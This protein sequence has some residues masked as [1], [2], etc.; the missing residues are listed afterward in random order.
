MK[1]VLSAAQGLLA[2]AGAASRRMMDSGDAEA[3]HDFRVGLR[4]LNT[5]LRAYRRILKGTVSA[6]TRKRLRRVLASTGRARDAQVELVWLKER[7]RGPSA[8]RGAGDLIAEVESRRDEELQEIRRT[9]LRR[10]RRLSGKLV[11][12]LA[13]GRG[14]GKALE[15][16]AGKVLDRRCAKLEARLPSREDLLLPEETHRLRISLRK[17]R[18]TL[19]PFEGGYPDCRRAIRGLIGVQQLL[20]ELHD[21]DILAVEFSRDSRARRLLRVVRAERKRL[22]RGFKEERLLREIR[23]VRT[24]ARALGDAEGARGRR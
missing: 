24:A 3:L 14:S 16:S 18:Y 12:A 4:R 22:H 21:R 9:A 13:K 1:T 8:L 11:R 19:E 15:A 10:F 6:K 20:G 23:G 17:L 2:G 7:L 5:H